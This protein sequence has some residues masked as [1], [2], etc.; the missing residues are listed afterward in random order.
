MNPNHLAII[1][2]FYLSKFNKQALANL[3][4]KNDSEA[5][6]A[7]ARIL[8]IKKNYIKFRRDEF[9]PVHPWRKGWQ[10]PMD[11]RI[12]R[13]IEAL[14]NLNEIDLREIVQGILSDPEY[15]N[16]ED[17]ERVTAL[18]SDDKKVKE[19]RKFILRGPTGKAAEEFYINYYSQ[20]KSP[21]AGTF[22]DCR[23]LGVGYDFRIETEKENYFIEVKGL[24]ELSGGVLFTNKEW[25]TAKETGNNY[26]LCIVSG[27]GNNPHLKLIH[28]P[29]ERLNPVKNICT[30]IQINWG[31]TSNQLLELK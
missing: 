24:S 12:V 27:I 10:R 15:R 22:V 26:Y 7:T 2:A 31:V 14:E 29:A 23:D 8:G 21:V 18:F 25:M 1:I 20:T 17:V 4:F 9:D 11:N 30:T 13:A 6:E 3:G 19:K 5:F 16:S 28:N